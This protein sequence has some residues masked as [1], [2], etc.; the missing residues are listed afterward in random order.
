VSQSATIPRAGLTG[1]V[2]ARDPADDAVKRPVK[3]PRSVEKIETASSLC[4][5]R[6]AADVLELL[7]SS[8]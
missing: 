2:T 8:A 4:A 5:E 1:R 6:A 3:R 7:G